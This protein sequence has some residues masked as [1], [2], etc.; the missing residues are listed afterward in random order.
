VSGKAKGSRIAL[1][2]G[3][4]AA[5]LV[6]L[7]LAG[8]LAYSDRSLIVTNPEPTGDAIEDAVLARIAIDTPHTPA[9]WLQR[10]RH[11]L[12]DRILED[13]VERGVILD[14]DETAMGGYIHLHRY[15]VADR[16][17]EVEIRQRLTEALTGRT[18][19]SE[20]TAALCTLLAA[21]RMEPAL[22][23]DG[24]A[25]VDAHKRLEEIASGAG[26]AG[27]VS[28]EESTIRPSVALVVATLGRAIHQ[29]LGAAR[30]EPPVAPPATPP[31][32]QAPDS[33]APPAAGSV[34][35]P[36]AGSGVPPVGSGQP[37][38]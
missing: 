30:V 2:L 38:E 6:E 25:L 16:S 14:V 10:L 27:T 32:P 1:D 7:A 34:P 19:P 23:L 22:G 37:G 26:F 18:V 15:P 12:R 5:V 9:S 28:L 24:E 13:L 11:G 3:M 21:T 31:A 33:A 4:V 35:P 8:R 29:A 17:V 20:R 36:S